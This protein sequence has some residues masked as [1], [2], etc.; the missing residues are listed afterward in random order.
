[1]EEAEEELARLRAE[2]TR[3]R[4]M[5]DRLERAGGT[6]PAP[7]AADT[8][9]IQAS[10][11]EMPTPVSTS[12]SP[13]R[14]K[15]PRRKRTRK[16]A[17]KKTS[18]LRACLSVLLVAGSITLAYAGLLILSIA[19]SDGLQTFNFWSLLFIGLISGPIILGSVASINDQI[20]K[21]RARRRQAALPRKPRE[22]PRRRITRKLRAATTQKLDTE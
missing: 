22:R 7:F 6:Q 5:I 12:S 10:E 8:Q 15:K 20:Q 13:E 2:N 19:L 14:P 18:F 21:Q 4:A 16:Q 17:K 9:I 11:D 3:L 1:M